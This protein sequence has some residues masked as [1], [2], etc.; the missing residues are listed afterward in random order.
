VMGLG[1]AVSITLPSCFDL[2]APVLDQAYA[3]AAPSSSNASTI[4]ASK[5]NHI[6]YGR[7]RRNESELVRFQASICRLEG[8]SSLEPGEIIDTPHVSRS[9]KRERTSSPERSVKRARHGND[10]TERPS[11]DPIFY[12]GPDLMRMDFPV[13]DNDKYALKKMLGEGGEGVAYLLEDRRTESLVVCKA[14]PHTRSH[15]KEDS[16]LHFLRDALPRHSRIIGLQ[17][18]L[19]RPYETELYLDSCTGGDLTSLIEA[20]EHW[21][22]PSSPGPYSSCSMDFIPESFI[23]H[24]FLQL[25]EAL[26]FIHHGY[27]RNAPSN[28]QKLPEKWL[29]VIHRDLKPGNILLQRAPT[30][31][32]HPGPEPYPKI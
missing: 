25:T 27:N 16:E 32:D 24:V 23:W 12:G 14:V 28:R 31:P 15:K 22:Q 4:K 8:R 5:Y 26:A 1:I 6:P 20:Y 7:S 19:V 29:S 9:R 2:P 11:N 21:G 3:Y 17:C 30:H 18:A 10:H 13:Q